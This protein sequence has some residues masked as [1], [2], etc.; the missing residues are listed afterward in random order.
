MK[1][2]KEIQQEKDKDTKSKQYTQLRDGVVTPGTIG[3]PEDIRVTY[4]EEQNP[5]DGQED[6][7]RAGQIRRE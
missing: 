7:S 5:D 2:L 3:L 6:A 1:S 4:S